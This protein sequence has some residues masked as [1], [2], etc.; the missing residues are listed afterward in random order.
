MNGRI[1][2]S[3]LDNDDPIALSALQHVSYCPRQYALIHLEQEFAENHHTL[4]GQAAHQRVDTGAMEMGY[5]G[6]RIERSVQLFSRRYGLV[7]KADVVEFHPDGRVFPVEYKQGRRRVK[8]HDNLQLAAQALCL[9]EMLGCRVTRGAIYSATSRKRREVI[10]D[11]ALRAQ[12]EAA[13]QHIQAIRTAN[14]LPPPV[15]DTRCKECSLIDLCQPELL[16]L[17]AQT[18]EG[19]WQT[20]LINSAEEG[21]PDV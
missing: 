20:S 19:V 10:I 13:I 6:V 2:Q 12:V 21:E 18:G 17:A 3:F 16:T 11:E 8:V 9:E 14:R 4:R 1:L 15:Q 5:E 7:G